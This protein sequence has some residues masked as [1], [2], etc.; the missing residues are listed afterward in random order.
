[1]LEQTVRDLD[2]L[3]ASSVP[4]GDPGSHAWRDSTRSFYTEDGLENIVELARSLRDRAAECLT[5]A[6]TVK[7]GYG[8]PQLKT[9][10]DV[11]AAVVLADSMHRSPGAPLDV[12]NNDAWNAPPS[13]ATE[14]IERGKELNRLRAHVD[15]LFD[16]RVLEQSHA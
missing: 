10:K 9:F 16:S 1:Q 13:D 4:I 3:A 5:H 11:E 8:F 2:D 15:K 12:L 6:E 7:H 14:L